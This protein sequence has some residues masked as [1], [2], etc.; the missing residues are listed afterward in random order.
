MTYVV[1]V[2]ATLIPA[3]MTG[4]TGLQ[5]ALDDP[6]VGDRDSRVRFELD[7]PAKNY[8]DNITRQWLLIAPTAN[9]AILAMFRD[10]ERVPYRNLLPWSGEFA[11]KYLTGATQVLHLT[12]DPA[13]QRC[14]EGF[15][16]ELIALQDTD[17]YIGPFPR[18]SRLSGQAPNTGEHGGPTWDAWGH[19]HAMLG[20]IFWYDETGSKPALA[21]ASRIGDLFCDRFLGPKRPRL[22]DTGS[23]EMNLAPAHALCLLHD[24]TGLVRYL[25]LARQIVDEFAETDPQN[26]PLAG[27]YLR[28]GLAAEPFYTTPKPRWESLHPILTL[29]SLYRTTGDARFRSAF[30]NLWWSIAELDRHNNGGFSSGEQA[31]GNPYHKGAIESCCTIAWMA[32]SVEMLRISANP[33]V[34]DELELSTL[35]SALGMFSPTGRWSTYNTPMDGVRKANYHEIVFQSRPGSPE[36]NCCS[37]NAARG[38]GLIGEWAVASGIDGLSLNWYG[39][40]KTTVPVASA[41]PVA[42]EQ[43]TEYPRSGKVDIRVE[44]IRPSEFTVRLR[45]PHWSTDTKVAINGK[46]ISGATAGQYLA[47][48]RGWKPGDLIELTLDFTPRFWVGERESLGLTSI[49]SGPILLAYDPRFNTIA[50]ASLPAID[51]RALKLVPSRLNGP[52]R[53]IVLFDVAVDGGRVLRLCDFASAGTDGSAYRTWLKVENVVPSPFS[54]ANPRRS[55]GAVVVK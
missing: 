9:P 48:T 53:P 10:R 47:L 33:V 24:R 40:G 4:A 44:P 2:L 46:S 52:L 15:V 26:R 14:L 37:V 30:E 16:R 42:L 22:V 13:L 5:V 38:L 51:A 7:G 49:Y 27:D 18:Q 3:T 11:G 23:T 35:N 41:G 21:A 43:Q 1:F 32:M 19:Y 45:I 31:Q 6:T 34:A 25:D 8:L 20:L 12:R 17:G 28:R 50:P 36:L 29:A 39:P 55:G 54:H